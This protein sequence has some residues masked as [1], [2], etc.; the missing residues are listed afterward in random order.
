MSAPVVLH[1]EVVQAVKRLCLANESAYFSPTEALHSWHRH[2]PVL[3][4][5]AYIT[6]DDA[7]LDR[8][9]ILEGQDYNLI[10]LLGGRQ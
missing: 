3:N 9:L 8:G 6:V 4:P 2:R 7:L 1:A 10:V 5:S